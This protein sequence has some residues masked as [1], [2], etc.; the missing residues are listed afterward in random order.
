MFFLGTDT[1]F[2]NQRRDKYES[3]QVRSPH[4]SVVVV[5][6]DVD[7]DK[8]RL[9]CLPLTT[10]E[11]SEI[12]YCVC[13]TLQLNDI[14]TTLKHTDV[15]WWLIASLSCTLRHCQRQPIEFCAC[16]AQIGYYCTELTEILQI[17]YSNKRRKTQF[18]FISS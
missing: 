12:G 7:F 17:G 18:L 8:G 2:A 11:F 10:E 14:K 9:I 3:T 1:L 4:L 13:P 6:A 15:V 5:V 16:V